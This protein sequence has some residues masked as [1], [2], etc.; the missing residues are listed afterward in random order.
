MKYEIYIDVFV[1]T[2]F[3]MDYLALFLANVFLGRKQMQRRLILSSI[4]GAVV[5][6]VLF[7]TLSSHLFYCL[8]IH[9]LLNPLMVWLAFRPKEIRRFVEVWVVTYLVILLMG[10]SMQWIYDTLFGGKYLLLSIAITWG[11]GMIAAFVWERQL[12]TGRRTYDVTLYLSGSEVSI[13]AYYDTGNLLTDPYVRQPVSIVSSAI[14][15]PL[16]KDYESKKRL[17]TFS[18]LGESDGLMEA[19]T[20]EKMLIHRK[21][22]VLVIEPAVLG[23]ADEK[24]FV[25]RDYQMILNSQLLQKQE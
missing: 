6:L 1:I 5:S 14:L 7:L 15:S 13:R 24:L 22:H 16:L 25:H 10:G 23:L 9:A 20:I 8:C 11:M 21:K 12:V 4:L 17:I 2:N 3:F 19:F 18:S